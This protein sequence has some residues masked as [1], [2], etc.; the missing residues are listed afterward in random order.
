MIIKLFGYN[1]IYAVTLLG[2]FGQYFQIPFC[3]PAL[4]PQLISPHLIKCTKEFC[5]AS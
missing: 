5:C 3:L 1:S 4:S 2:D